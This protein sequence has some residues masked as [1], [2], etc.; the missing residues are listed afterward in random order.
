M[1][2]VNGLLKYCP[3]CKQWLPVRYF[4]KP[5]GKLRL[6][7]EI[8]V[9]DDEAVREYLSEV[10]EQIKQEQHERRFRAL[11]EARARGTKKLSPG[12]ERQFWNLAS[13]PFP[14]LWR[15]KGMDANYTPVM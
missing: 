2:D 12:A 7:C 13:D 15:G 14:E 3:C 4:R 10:G 1:S 8:C 9:E 11:G 5:R 6:L